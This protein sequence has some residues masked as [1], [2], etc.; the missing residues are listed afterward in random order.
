MQSFILRMENAIAARGIMIMTIP[1]ELLFLKAV[2]AM[3]K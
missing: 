2:S 1:Q 3:E